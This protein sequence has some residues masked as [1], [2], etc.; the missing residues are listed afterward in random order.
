[1]PE[2]NSP[3]SASFFTDRQVSQ[4]GIGISTY[5]FLQ[6][7][8]KEN[9]RRETSRVRMSGVVSA[10]S[11]S[12]QADHFMRE[13]K[14]EKWKGRPFTIQFEDKAGLC[15]IPFDFQ[16]IGAPLSQIHSYTLIPTPPPL[17]PLHLC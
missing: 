8:L 11:S 14:E 9:R 7:I 3:A 10:S 6:I 1:M 4:S 15:G 12:S 17:P 13:N 16:K 2:K 5:A